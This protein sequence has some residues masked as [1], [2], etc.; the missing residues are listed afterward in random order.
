MTIIDLIV[1][2]VYMTIVITMGILCRGKQEDVADYFTTHGHMGGI[3][4]SILVGMS[5]AATLFSGISFIAYPSV[6]YTHGIMFLLSMLSFPICWLILHYWFLPRYLSI[7]S[8]DPYGF[9]E[10]RFGKNV[11]QVA[12][13]MFA[14]LRFSWMAA[15]IYA[16][17]LAIMAAA[18]LDEHWFWPLILIIGL[19]S[20]IY[21]ALGGIRGVIITDA[22]QF[23]MMIIGIS[24]T[25][26]YALVKLPIPL[27]KTVGILQEN[28]LLSMPSFSLDP[29]MVF[30]FWTIIIGILVSNL[31]SYTG[32]QM[33]LQRYLATGNLKAC[34]RSFLIN[35]SGVCFV[36]ILLAGIGL[37]LA[38]WYE[39]VP[40]PDLPG[41]ADLIFPHFVSSQLPAGIAGGLLSAILAATMS[42]ITSGINTLSATFTLDFYMKIKKNVT[43]KQQ[44]KVARYASCVIG[45]LS[46]L[47]A[48]CVG[49]LGDIFT[50]AQTLLGV[51]IGP[52]MACAILALLN[53][54]VSSKAV[55]SGMIVGSVAGVCII[56]SPVSALWISPVAFVTA[57]AIPL[58]LSKNKED[59]SV[60][61]YNY[62]QEEVN[63]QT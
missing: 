46:T 18:K 19:S 51:F 32:D 59:F 40:D 8:D 5:I 26:G 15:L 22:I 23:L 49:V 34:S 29:T 39:V 27:H 30:T 9:I 16:P 4:G 33:S 56:F 54:K 42:S 61:D 43:A 58:L 62:I 25:I 24:F 41:K 10:I 31:G 52:L 50:I 57:L 7:K 3:T 21:T 37:S 14:L 44:I 12:A 63:N 2:I 13:V 48:G 60:D 45:L 6:I 38:V 17:T 20:S 1:I 55:I 35:I 47:A 11:R 36:S 53:K 28:N